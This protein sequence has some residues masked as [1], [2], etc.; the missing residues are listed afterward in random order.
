MPSTHV[1]IKRIA[2]I[3]LVAALTTSTQVIAQEER[4]IDIMPFLT[5]VDEERNTERQAAGLRTAFG[6]QTQGNWYTEVQL[7]GTK[8]DGDDNNL[9]APPPLFSGELYPSGDNEV[10]GLGMDAVYSFNGRNGYSPFLLGGVGVAHNNTKFDYGYDE[11][12]A[13]VNL[14]FGI[15]SGAISKDGLKI[16]AEVRYVRDFFA[17]DM[18][19][20]QFGFGLSIPLSCPPVATPV[21]APP[22]P[23]PEPE[24]INVDS[25]GDGVLDRN[26]RCP[27]TLAGAEVDQYGCVVANQTITLENIQF[28]FN[29]ATLTARAETSLD[30][31]VQSLRDQT[32]TQV[33]VAGHTDSQGNDS[34]NLRLSGQRAESVRRYLVQNGISASRITAKGYGETQPVATNA[35][36]AGRAQNR[37]VELTFR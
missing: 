33:E 2:G 8:L 36:E 17:G 19:D 14:G 31:V 21:A 25:D 12:N 20:W 37:R 6:W 32:N 4:Y 3:A 26:D 29:S 24:I 23:E 5:R 16:R 9:I 11:T 13:F 34:Y 35:T 1:S 27:N 22:P 18:N 10:A 30:K 15:T 7:F 28:E